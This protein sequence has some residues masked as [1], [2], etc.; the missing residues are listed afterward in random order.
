LDHLSNALQ[1]SARSMLTR[2]WFWQCTLKARIISGGRS[3]KL[4]LDR[5]VGRCGGTRAG[6]LATAELIATAAK[7]IAPAGAGLAPAPPAIG[8]G[9]PPRVVTKD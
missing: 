4:D 6:K 9:V 1:T 7:P 2:V 5:T 8:K 3:R